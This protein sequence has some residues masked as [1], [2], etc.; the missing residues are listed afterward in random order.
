MLKLRLMPGM[1]LLAASLTMSLPAGEQSFDL[2][3]HTL[4]GG[5]GTNIVGGAFELSGTIG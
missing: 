5:G 3:W 4:D 2:T 1:T